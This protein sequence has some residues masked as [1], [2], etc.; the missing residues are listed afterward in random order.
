[1]II[2]SGITIGSGVQIVPDGISYPSPLLHLDASAYSGS[3]STWTANT[4]SNATLYNTPTYTSASPTTPSQ[5]TVTSVVP[6]GIPQ[7]SAQ[8]D[9][10]YKSEM[11]KAASSPTQ[12]DSSAVTSTSNLSAAGAQRSRREEDQDFRRWAM[13]LH[14]YPHHAREFHFRQS[15]FRQVEIG[16][17][18]V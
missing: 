15:Q 9:A 3:G 6:P 4:G 1:M 2:G 14:E 13:Q 5:P 10:M 18:H 17:A 12:I 16:R 8:A 11:I 7:N